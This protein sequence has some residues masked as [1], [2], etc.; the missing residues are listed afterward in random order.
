MAGAETQGTEIVSFRVDA[1]TYRR[2]EELRQRKH[3]NVSSF[4]REAIIEALD[5]DYPVA[6]VDAESISRAVS[7]S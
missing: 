2:L 7:R 1:D 6:P 3:L 5:R 4:V